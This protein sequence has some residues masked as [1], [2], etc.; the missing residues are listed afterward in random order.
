MILNVMFFAQELIFLFFLFMFRQASMQNKLI[1]PLISSK[2]SLQPFPN[3]QQ[4]V[5]ML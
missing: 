4:L 3:P 2:F 5:L 1:G